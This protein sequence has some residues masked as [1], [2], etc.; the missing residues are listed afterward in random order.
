MIEACKGESDFFAV[1]IICTADIVMQFAGMKAHPK[2]DVFNDL[3]NILAHA[4]INKYK[5]YSRYNL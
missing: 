5:I 2:I 4:I 1:L 3:I